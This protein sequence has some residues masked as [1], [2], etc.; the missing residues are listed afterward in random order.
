MHPSL[1]KQRALT[2]WLRATG[3]GCLVAACFMPGLYLN[4][5]SPGVQAP[6]LFTLA[7][8]VFWA[9]ALQAK[10]RAWIWLS[11]LFALFN[12]LLIFAFQGGAAEPFSLLTYA[13]WL[14]PM[15]FVWSLFAF[16]ERYLLKLAEHR[17]GPL[18][19]DDAWRA[20]IYGSY[21]LIPLVMLGSSLLDEIDASE[22]VMFVLLS[23]GGLLSV[24][25]YVQS[26]TQETERAA[27]LKRAAL[28]E[29]PHYRV[30]ESN[31]G[32][33][34]L[35]RIA[36]TKDATAYRSAEPEHEEIAIVGQDGVVTTPSR[37]KVV[38][39]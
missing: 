8:S 33:S 23:V 34:V 16:P 18:A 20:L 28:G 27:F 13:S 2:R 6:A 17:G 38:Q 36:E 5:P 9:R 12:A 11:P 21:T 19:R 37:K 30:I 35:V 24:L 15:L 32:Q 29:E 1:L 3:T 26:R 14:P 22:L 4:D 7:L 25:P 39:Q 10:G 31:E